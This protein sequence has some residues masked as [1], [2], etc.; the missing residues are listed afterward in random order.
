[1]QSL[2]L[3]ILA[4]GNSSRFGGNPKILSEVGPNNETLFEMS[5]LEMRDYINIKQ[6]HM[7]LNEKT[8][9][10]ILK[11]INSVII[12]HN[13]DVN[14]T[15]TI[16]KI[17]KN[18]TKPWG[19]AD[20]L[21]CAVGDINIPFILLNSDDLY[22]RRTYENISKNC[23][24][25]KNYIIGYKLGSTLMRDKPANRAIIIHKDNEVKNLNEKLQIKI[26]DFTSEELNNTYVSVNLLLLQPDVLKHLY[27]NVELFKNNNRENVNC[28]AMLPDFI[29][30]LLNKEKLKLELMKTDG[31]WK[32]VTYKEDVNILQ[33]QLLL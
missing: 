2:C 11:M 31:S 8:H 32:G 10:K 22:S 24:L 23:E 13:L 19:T 29:N 14:I 30:L 1:M 9:E 7:I 5:L 26:D 15:H 18:R 27:I 20:A 33:K 21:S 17:P 3:L 6:I 4:A 16:Q 28:E 12:K 25:N